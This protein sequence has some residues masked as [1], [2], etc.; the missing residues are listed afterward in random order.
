[1]TGI[2]ELQ[3]QI[4]EWADALSPRRRPE[5]TMVK[6]SGESSELLDAIV[7]R[8]GREAVESELGDCIIL[9]LDIAAMYNIDLVQAGFKKME[10]NRA[11]KWTSNDGVIRRVKSDGT[12]EPAAV[13][14][15][16]AVSDLLHEQGAV[17]SGA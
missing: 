5:N 2:A 15:S 11:R 16:E 10:V 7:N 3:R 12:G 8:L 9:L 13:D 14:A 4:L 1:M 6:L 17:S